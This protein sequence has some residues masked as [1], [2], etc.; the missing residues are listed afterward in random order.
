VGK[1]LKGKMLQAKAILLNQLNQGQV[2]I[3]EIK[4]AHL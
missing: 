3:M 2:N 1:T 4:F